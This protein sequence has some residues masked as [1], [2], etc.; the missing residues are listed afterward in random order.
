ML[1]EIIGTIMAAGPTLEKQRVEREEAH[2]R[3]EEEQ[4][5]RYEAQRLKEIDDKRWKRFQEFASNWEQRGKLLPFITELETRLAVEGDI[6]VGDKPLSAWIAWARAR[7]EV[8]DPFARGAAGLFETI[9]R[10]TQWS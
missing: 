3:Y 9:A 6:T 5:R 8:L 4:A 2:R 7:A 1:P 10:V